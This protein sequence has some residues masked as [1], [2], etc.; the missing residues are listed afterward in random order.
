MPG[1]RSHLT[2]S[3]RFHYPGVRRASEADYQTI[4]EET[5][6][7]IIVC[8]MKTGEIIDANPRAYDMIGRAGKAWRGLN[9]GEV[10][11]GDGLP[12]KR[13]APWWT[14]KHWKELRFAEWLG[15]DDLG[16][17]LWVEVVLKQVMTDVHERHLLIILH[18]ISDRKSQEEQFHD[19]QRMGAPEGSVLRICH[20]MNHV[21]SIL[22]DH[23]ETVLQSLNDRDPI[24]GNIDEILRAARIAASLA[25]QFSAFAQKHILQPELLDL[26]R[27]LMDMDETIRRIVGQNIKLAKALKWPLRK[28]KADRGQ[29]EQIVTNLAVNARDGMSEGGKLTLK[30]ENVALDEAP[31]NSMPHAVPGEFV[32][33][34]VEYTGIGLVPEQVDRLL[35]FSPAAQRPEEASTGLNFSIAAASVKQLG[36]WINVRGEPEIGLRLEIYLPVFSLNRQEEPDKTTSSKDVESGRE[37]VGLSEREESLRQFVRR[38]F[39]QMNGPA[40]YSRR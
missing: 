10:E 14:R 22:N 16:R 21:I 1:N 7:G 36:G 32:C 8:D 26:N 17:K 15:E 20:D 34:T 2:R 28:I 5:C 24:Q 6:D 27:L 4:F 3:K 9:L 30:T 40:M 25:E 37:Q 38:T 23:V 39:A 11:C 29:I 12:T 31:E 35:D 13:D 18:D 33:L 19:K